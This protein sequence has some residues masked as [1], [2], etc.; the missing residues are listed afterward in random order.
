MNEN[1]YITEAEALSDVLECGYEPFDRVLYF[2][3]LWEELKNEGS[4]WQDR[5]GK[6]YTAKKLKKDKRRLKNIVN[7]AKRNGRPLEQI[8]VLESLL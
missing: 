4:V 1:D 6:R 3:E 8:E 2:I 5:F 7:F